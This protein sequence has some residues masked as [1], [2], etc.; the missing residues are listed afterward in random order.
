MVSKQETRISH[1]EFWKIM[2]KWYNTDLFE[3]DSHGVWHAK[4]KVGES[5]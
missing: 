4:F 2:D 5:E 1:S 3:K